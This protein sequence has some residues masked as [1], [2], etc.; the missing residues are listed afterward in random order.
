MEP[1]TFILR[2]AGAAENACRFIKGIN[3]N[4]DDL[5]EVIVR[6]H[7][8]KRTD[9]QNKLQWRIMVQIAG[10]KGDETP[11][12][13]QAYC[14]LHVGVPILRAENDD[15]REKYDRVVKPLPYEVKLEIM[16]GKFSF[17]V[18]SIMTTKQ[19]SRYIEEVARHFAQQGIYVSLPSDIQDRAA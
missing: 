1:Q 10:A 11:E 2:D 13:I 12:D 9:P 19:K 6:D 4:P 3:I 18:T 17:P 8:K 16:K 5:L 14:K 7:E 15:F